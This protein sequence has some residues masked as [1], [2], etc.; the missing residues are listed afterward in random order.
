MCNDFELRVDKLTKEL[1]TIKK[2]RKDFEK[3]LEGKDK[4]IK[5]L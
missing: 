1:S 5:K 2:E 3:T 4:E